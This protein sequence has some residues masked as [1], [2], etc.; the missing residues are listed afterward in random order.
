MN[1]VILVISLTLA[2]AGGICRNAVLLL[3]A[4]IAIWL[5]NVIFALGDIKRR[6]LFLMFHLTYFLFILGRPLLIILKGE[7]LVGMQA[8][9]GADGDGV[10]LTAWIIYV[11]LISIWLGERL[12]HYISQKRKDAPGKSTRVRL[13][14]EQLR[15][16]RRAAGIVLV[17]SFLA[18]FVMRAE[19]L[20]FILNHSYTAS[21]ADFKSSMPYML[22]LLSTFFEYAVYL[23]LVTIPEKK[24][25][26]PV[27]LAYVLL[28]VPGLLGGERKQI[29]LAVLFCCLYVVFRHYYDEKEKWIGKKTVIMGGIGLIAGVLVLGLANYYRDGASFGSLNPFLLIEDFVDKQGVTFSWICAAISKVDI[30]RSQGVTSY[31]FGDFLDYAGHGTFA[32]VVFGAS[33][34]TN[35]NSVQMATES[36]SMA[37]HLSYLLM[38]KAYLTGHGTG[39]SFLIET[40]TDFG[41][42]GLIIFCI[43]LGGLF[44]YTWSLCTQSCITRLFL[45][46][47]TRGILFM[48]RAA[49]LA[50]ISFLWRIAFWCCLCVCGVL[51]L[52]IRFAD[53]KR[54]KVKT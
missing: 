6:A 49:S 5:H 3:C 20:I 7:D 46:C 2:A 31:T 12:F 42:T 25:A 18:A 51:Y 27:M 41:W 17:V 54:E 28:E 15:E 21:Y 30:L 45:F 4:G 13:D 35:T 43:L 47:T 34:L 36:N 33:S 53:R 26:V 14:K 9:Y 50:G 32:Q 22:Y 38:G 52:L 48:P 19:K 11:S 10:I 44:F 29:C 39:S 40:F 37:H 8:A 24:N 1:A 23:Y 16:I